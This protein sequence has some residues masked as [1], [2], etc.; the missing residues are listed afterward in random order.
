M[1]GESYFIGP[2]LKSARERLGYSQADLAKAVRVDPAMVSR[3]EFSESTRYTAVPADRLVLLAKYLDVDIHY[4]AP[5]AN[6]AVTAM[7]TDGVAKLA[8]APPMARYATS[9]VSHPSPVP[10]RP[11][12]AENGEYRLRLRCPSCK[13]RNEV[14]SADP[15]QLPRNCLGCGRQLRARV[16]VTLLAR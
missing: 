12:R 16:T 11:Q 6:G 15:S 13:M 4:L 2:R 1:H 7:M 3:W 14:L 8:K 9:E 5:S 10:G